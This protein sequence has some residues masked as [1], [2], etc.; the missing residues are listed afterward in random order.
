[1]PETPPFPG[2]SFDL[3]EI[4][5]SSVT[6]FV[7]PALNELIINRMKTL[8]GENIEVFVPKKGSA[9]S[10]KGVFSEES[11]D[12]WVTHDSQ[13]LGKWMKKDSDDNIKPSVIIA[14][15]KQELLDKCVIKTRTEKYCKLKSLGL[16]ESETNNSYIILPLNDENQNDTSVQNLVHKRL[17]PPVRDEGGW[18]DGECND[19]DD[20]PLSISFIQRY[21]LELSNNALFTLKRFSESLD[22]KKVKLS[23]PC[24]IDRKLNLINYEGENEAVHLRA[25]IIHSGSSIGSGHY[26]TLIVDG[27][28]LYKLNDI[29]SESE[30]YMQEIEIGFLT[31]TDVTNNT[32]LICYSKDTTS[33]RSIEEMEKLSAKNG[34]NNCYVHS[35]FSFLYFIGI[36]SAEH[37]FTQGVD[38]CNEKILGVQNE[39]FGNR[40]QQDASELLDKIFLFE[41]IGH[42]TDTE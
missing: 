5:Y 9:L 23:T 24:I 14:N 28:R 2:Q 38:T 4:Q 18:E 30:K 17:T 42:A 29:R 41:K 33:T 35:L 8:Y 32:V 21:K 26:Y 13:W 12:P 25:I 16:R 40:K 15:I 31:S 37:L 27:D 10:L 1:M 3:T 36:D 22:G 7:Q 34:N 6:E 11:V 19:K 20:K 39:L